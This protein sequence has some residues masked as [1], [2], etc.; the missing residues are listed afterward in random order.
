MTDRKVERH[1]NESKSWRIVW[2]ALRGNPTIPDPPHSRI[3]YDWYRR[4]NLHL[5][6]PR[7]G[8]DGRGFLTLMHGMQATLHHFVRSVPALESTI[9]VKFTLHPR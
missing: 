7:A 2:G 3:V 4:C 9:K 6:G 8:N 5:D 1:A